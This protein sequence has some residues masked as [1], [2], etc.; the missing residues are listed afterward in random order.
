MPS[1]V[2][3][4][5]LAE[6]LEPSGNWFRELRIGEKPSMPLLRVLLSKLLYTEEPFTESDEVQC[7]TAFEWCVNKCVDPMFSRKYY[8]QLSLFKLLMVN[9]EAFVRDKAAISEYRKQ[10]DSYYSHGRKFL[11]ASIFY[12]YRKLRKVRMV[13]LRPKKPK[14]KNR[15]GVGYRDMGNARNTAWDG[16]PTWQ[17]VASHVFPVVLKQQSATAFERAQ[18]LWDCLRTKAIEPWH[19]RRVA[20]PPDS[21]LNQFRG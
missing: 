1:V 18:F 13:A 11:S 12:G 19:N 10:L 7:F 3:A 16:S 2:K 15:I 6:T 8:F 14:N 9:F 4:D 5:P 17:E 20:R 21:L